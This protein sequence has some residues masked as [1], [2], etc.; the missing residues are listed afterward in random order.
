MNF[1]SYLFG[2]FAYILGALLLLFVLKITNYN[3]FNMIYVVGSVISLSAISWH[4]FLREI[5]WMPTMYEK[6]QIGFYLTCLTP[7]LIFIIHFL[8]MPYEFLI[9]YILISSILVFFTP[10]IILNQLTKAWNKD[11]DKKFA[12]EQ[13]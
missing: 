11:L 5:K 13:V 2:G 10:F 4:M 1:K 8:I 3:K 6:F 9:T 7:F 12:K